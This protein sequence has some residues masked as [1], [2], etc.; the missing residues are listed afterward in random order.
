VR[1]HSERLKSS[2]SLNSA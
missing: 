2:S 1:Y